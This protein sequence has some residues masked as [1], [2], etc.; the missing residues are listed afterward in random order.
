MFALNERLIAATAPVGYLA[1]ST[2]LMLDDHRFR[3]LLLVPRREGIEEIYQ[4]PQADR[5]LLIDE[6]AAASEVLR[7]R[8]APFRLNIADIGNRAPQLHIHIVARFEDDV[9]WPKTVWSREREAYDSA[10]L[11]MRRQEMVGAFSALEGFNA[12]R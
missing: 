12:A 10:T 4:M 3:W 6:I 11:E 1:L 7:D 9:F 5:H 8:Y 2:V